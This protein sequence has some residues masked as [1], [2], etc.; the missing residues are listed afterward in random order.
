M[1]LLIV[2]HP[3]VTPI[4]Q[5]FYAAVEQQTDWNLTIVTPANWNNQYGSQQAPQRWPEFRGQLL[6]IPVWKSGNIP[7]HTYRS[8]FV[9]LLRSLQPDAI[10]VHHEAH[11]V[12]T[13]QV[14]LANRLSLRCPIGFYSAQNI[15]KAYPPPFRQAERMVL[16]TS[17]FA[18][19]VSQSVKQVLQQKGYQGTATVLPLGVDLDIYTPH[20]QAQETANRLRSHPQEVLIGYLGRIAEEKGLKTLL[21]ALKQIEDLPWRFV[22]VGAGSYEA[23]CD[24]LAQ[25]LNLSDRIQKIGF[26]PHDEA[27][28]YLSAF[29]VLVLPSETRPHWKEQ[30][31]RVIIE[32]LACGTPVVGSD[33]GEIPNVI[34]ATKGGVV[35]PEGQPQALAEQ[36]RALIL[37]SSLRSHL[38]E[39]GRQMVQSHYTNGA[40]AQSFANTIETSMKQRFGDSEKDQLVDNIRADSFTQ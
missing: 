2:S 27:P 1:K 36:L 33:S 9:P 32:A 12:A 26:V 38:V 40:L 34:A 20:P 17:N 18:Y 19:P 13:A 39:Q 21:Q 30:F 11:A 8:L 37:N 5:Q 10:Y 31:G 6:S 4:N 7:L 14:Y 35:F 3:C 23:E 29:D 25:S 24:R 15:L 16:Q 22:L 28:E